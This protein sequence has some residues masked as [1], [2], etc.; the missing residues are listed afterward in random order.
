MEAT[1]VIGFRK[2]KIS[3]KGFWA[4]SHH[5]RSPTTLLPYAPYHIDTW[6][7]RDA[8]ARC[9]SN[10][11]RINSGRYS[12]TTPHK[13]PFPDG[14]CGLWA[15]YAPPTKGPWAPDMTEGVIVAWGTIVHHELGFRAEHARIVCLIDLPSGNMVGSPDPR[16]REILVNRVLERYAI[17]LLS[18]GEAVEYASWYGAS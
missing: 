1:R 4:R 7:T 15:N 11:C 17:P 8:T 14:T 10:A 12:D 16:T 18:V 6:A 5:S 2:W 3:G 9:W 13:A